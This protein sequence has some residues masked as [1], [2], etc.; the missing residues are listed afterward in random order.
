MVERENPI[1]N[2]N[3][4]LPIDDDD[5]L[6]FER[7]LGCRLPEEYRQ[8]LLDHNGS[9]FEREIIAEQ[10]LGVHHLFSLYHGP[11]FQRLES[12]WCLSDYYDLKHLS[13]KLKRYLVFGDCSTG[14]LLLLNLV[15]GA[16]ELFDHEAAGSRGFFG[17]FGNPL[18]GIS[19]LASGF[20]S[21]VNGLISSEES[22]AMLPDDVRLDVE[23]RLADFEKEWEEKDEKDA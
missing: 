21:F 13:G 19:P 12:N 18:R 14:D 9:R 15:T 2:S 23:R 3:P 20:D 4:Y 1:R 11:D 5:I 7:T 16:V 22:L 8:Y 17:F 6:A 10:G